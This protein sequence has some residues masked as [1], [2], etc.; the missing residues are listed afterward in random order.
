MKR[1]T[2]YSLSLA[3]AAVAAAV[4]ALGAS[5]PPAYADGCLDGPCTV[6]DS[7]E[8]YE[9]TCGFAYPACNCVYE[10]VTQPQHACN[11]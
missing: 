8:S 7:G 11:S 6:F 1:T 5:A 10:G 4:L 3:G 2:D 9:G